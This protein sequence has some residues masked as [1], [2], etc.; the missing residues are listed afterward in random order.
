[1]PPMRIALGAD[2]AGFLLKEEVK[3]F[4]ASRDIPFEDFGT[5]SDAS[6]DYPDYAVRV[7]RSVASG[8]SDRGI[9][10]CGTGIGMAIA[11][12]KVAGIRAAAI[13]DLDAARLSREHNDLN[14][15]ALGGRVT[16]ADRAIDLVRLFLD[17]PYA[18]GRHQPR[19]DKIAGLEN[20]SAREGAGSPHSPGR[21]GS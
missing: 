4:L 14:V 5:H 3:R 18:A 16:T 8:E 9:L 20:Q 7:A 13:T 11:A 6:V 10:V 19:L 17:T 1:M 12:N 15:L 21:P 2:H